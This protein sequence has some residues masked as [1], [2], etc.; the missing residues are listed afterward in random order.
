MSN[1]EARKIVERENETVREQTRGEF[2][3]QR[4]AREN[5]HVTDR[6]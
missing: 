2:R 5:R 4:K 1:T 6:L 3:E